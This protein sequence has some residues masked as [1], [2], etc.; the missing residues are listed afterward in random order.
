M[1]ENIFEL[2]QVAFE[3][4]DRKIFNVLNLEIKS[5]DFIRIIGPSGSGKSTLMK[6]IASLISPTSGE[7]F[8]KGEPLLEQDLLKYRQKVSYF[9]QN[10]RLFGKTVYENLEFPYKV[11]GREFDKERVIE[12]LHKVN[13][14]ES[15]INKP[16]N[17]LSGGEAQRIAFV[18]NMIM[19]PEVLLLD[20]V[21]S[22]L[23]SKNRDQII[24]WVGDLN[25]QGKTVFWITHFEKDINE[26]QKTLLVADGKA[27]FVD[28]TAT[29]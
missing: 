13:L 14:D 23:D 20:E 22:S 12:L 27:E 2:Q 4:D 24:S 29:N 25:K 28:G 26:S 9:F 1:E 11:S 15:Y 18:R 6:L 19:D 17:D 7:I 10:P 5:G 21:T 3:V 16:I 8:Y